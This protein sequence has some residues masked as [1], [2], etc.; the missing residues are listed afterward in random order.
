M[1]THWRFL[2]CL[3]LNVQIGSTL[4]NQWN[5][6]Q[7]FEFEYVLPGVFPPGWGGTMDGSVVTDCQIAHSGKCSA[8]I[9]RQR[10]ISGT[11]SYL[12]SSIAI[13]SPGTTV[14][15]S[16]WVRTSNVG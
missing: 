10:S 12:Q 15:W 9:T 6:A 1:R 7:M 14:Q 8:R 5:L 2:L 13:P 4:V 11:F 3:T 16:G